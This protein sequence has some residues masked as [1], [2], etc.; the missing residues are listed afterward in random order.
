VVGTRRNHR[1]KNYITSTRPENASI[2]CKTNVV[3]ER[4]VVG[5]ILETIDNLFL[6]N[7]KAVAHWCFTMTTQ[8]KE[9][10][11]LQVDA[12]PKIQR[13]ALLLENVLLR[14]KD[15]NVQSSLSFYVGEMKRA[16]WRAFIDRLGNWLQPLKEDLDDFIAKGATLADDETY[17]LMLKKLEKHYETTKVLGIPLDFNF[18]LMQVLK[19][20]GA[21][22]STKDEKEL[23]L[24]Y[25][26]YFQRSFLALKAAE[27]EK[28]EQ[29]V[30]DNNNNTN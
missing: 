14:C 20:F 21:L 5:F 28:E 4:I 22:S 11:L 8:K 30:D 27:Q 2:S 24:T 12:P 25:C 17:Y 29:S 10:V 9:L 15:P 3:Q 16:S 13:F 1:P 26:G 7:S 6:I 18:V 23:V 19:Q